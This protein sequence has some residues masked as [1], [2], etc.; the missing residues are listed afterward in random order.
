MDEEVRRA[1]AE[2]WKPVGEPTLAVPKD[3]ALPKYWFQALCL[4]SSPIEVERAN[5]PA[6]VDPNLGKNSPKL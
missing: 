4:S 2:G 5:I 1:I 3:L 6:P